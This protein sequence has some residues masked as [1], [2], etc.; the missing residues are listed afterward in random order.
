MKAYRIHVQGIVQAV[1][2]RPFV[3]RIAHAHNL[4]GYVRNLGDAGVEIVVEG[5]EED[6]EGFLRDLYRKKPPIAKIEKVE[7]EEIPIQGFDR[8]Y[9]EKSSTE[10]KGEG[11]S[12]IPPDIAICEDCLRE[13]FDPTNKRYM[14]PFIVCTNCGPRFT[15]IEDLPY[16]RENTAMR[17]FPMCDFCKSEYEDPLNRRYH[18]EPVAC[19]V[20]GPSYRLY[21]SDGKEITGDPL[22]KAAKLID[23]GYIIAIKGIGGIHLAC[24]A[25]RE[26]VVA[27]LRKRLFRP[28]KPFAIMAKD[29]ET[30][31]GFA[32]ISRE[33]EEELTSYRRPIVALRK[34]EPFP[35]PENLA[36]GLHTIG[37]MLPYAGTHYI[38]FHW[39]K[40]PVYVMTSANFPGMPMIK[41]N[42][43]AFEKLKD[44]A[45]YLLLHNRRIP[46]RAD[47]SV[48]RFVDGRRAVIRRSRGFVPLWIEIP[49]EYKGLA[50]GAELMNAFGVAKNG[51]VYPSQYIGNTSKIE[52]LEFMREAIKHFFK[53]LRINALDL[54]VADLHPNYNTTKLAMEI[55]EEFNAEFLQVQ[56]HYAHVA[57]VMA[58]HNLEEVVGIALDGVGYGTDGKTW[59]GEII[60]LSYEDIER[61]AHLEYYPLPG[62]DLASYYPLRALIGILSLNH[63]IEE[64]ENTIRKFCPNAIKSL[65]YGETELKVILRQLSSGINVAYASSTGRVLDAFSVLLNVSYRRHYEGEPA[66][67]LESFASQ[68]K[69][70]LKLTIPVEGEEIRVSELFEEVL[71]LMGKASPR[72]IAYSIHLALARVF[73][74]VSVEKAKEFGAKTVVLGGGVGY[75]ELI[76]KTVRKIVEGNGLKF[77][78]TYEVPRGDN[79][80]NVGQAFLGGLYLEGYLNRE[81]LSI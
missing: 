44:V 73:A 24:D 16:D 65:K 29:L 43:E 38:L 55:A 33:E 40:T 54:V 47:D 34:R 2:F 28:Q 56:H 68:G 75:N 61:L 25:T 21:T 19:P 32:Y 49:F 74:E 77:L 45:D 80:I 30:V 1:G 9:I 51:K 15:I 58:E 78:T 23:K 26:D 48:V 50:V 72:D 53:I 39:S 22:R 27:E 69:N 5:R 70:D 7:R 3:Y 4:R 11:D 66:M 52:V 36:P 18:A 41:D 71:D 59:G 10:K 81:D 79:G 12:I 62:G 67:K 42:E 20:C 64:V 8:F 63:E 14:Y 35:L 6:I 46:N 13:L 31:K 60:Y 37:V 57:S 76:V 17:E